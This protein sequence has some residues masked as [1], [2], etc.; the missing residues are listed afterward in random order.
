MDDGA[1]H[2]EVVAGFHLKDGIVGV[3]RSQFYVPLV[4]MCQV[5]E[6]HGETSIPPSQHDRAVMRFHSAVY[7]DPV[8]IEYARILHRVALY[9]AIERS[10]WIQNEIAVKIQRL[11]HLVISRRRKAR[12]HACMFQFQLRVKHAFHNLDISHLHLNFMQRTQF[13]LK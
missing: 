12:H 11:V 3:G 1:P 5:E 8:A 4:A 7:D 2:F 9:L 13:F 6:F 10:L